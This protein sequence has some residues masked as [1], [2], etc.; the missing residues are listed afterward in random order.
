EI[1]VVDDGSTDASGR[2]ARSWL[3]RDRRIRLVRQ[4][5]R[6]LSAARNTG[7][8]HARGEFLAFVDSDDVVEQDAYADAIATLT[9]TGSDFA[10]MPYRRIGP[11]G[12][13]VPRDWIGAAHRVRRERARLADVPGILVNVVAWTKVYRR[14][15]WD[16]AG[17]EFPVG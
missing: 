15:F 17:M 2:L 4:P 12:L 5:N 14:E 3:R 7:V 13:R 16:A 9:R 11:D 6:G 8:R 1:I 10:V